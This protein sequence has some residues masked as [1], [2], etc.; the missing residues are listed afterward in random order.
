VLIGVM[1]AVVLEMSGIPSLAFAVGVYLPLSSST[2]IL[3]GG[4][5]RYLAD[6]RTEAALR[7]KLKKKP[8]EEE[9]AEEGDKSPGVMLSSGYIAGG[10][11]AGIVIAFV[12]GLFGEVQTKIDDWA[13]ANNPLVQDWTKYGWPYDFSDAFSLIPFLV[14]CVVLHYVA[15]RAIAAPK[16]S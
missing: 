3:A 2:P 11:I 8:S 9:L 5:L 16:A 13:L 12:A 7:A 15:T 14:I 4:I 10:A 1:I 6:R